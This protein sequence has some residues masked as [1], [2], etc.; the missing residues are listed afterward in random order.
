VILKKRTVRRSPRKRD[1]IYLIVWGLA[2][3]VSS[4]VFLYLGYQ[5]DQAH[6]TEPFFM[7]GLFLLAVAVC[8]GRFYQVVWRRWAEQ[9]LRESEQRLYSIRLRP[10]SWERITA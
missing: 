7:I 3:V 10:L 6:K 5:I 8:I 1:S 2:L 4:F 9:E